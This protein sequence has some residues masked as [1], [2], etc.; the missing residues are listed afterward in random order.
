M[1]TAFSWDGKL[2]R[3]PSAGLRID[4][5]LEALAASAFVAGLRGT[6]SS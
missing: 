6:A 4:G 5:T 2:H 1:R 3:K